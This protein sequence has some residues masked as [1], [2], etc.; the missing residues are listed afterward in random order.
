MYICIYATS[1]KTALEYGIGVGKKIE[2]GLKSGVV[3]KEF[4]ENSELHAVL[5]IK[6]K[7]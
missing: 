5:A 1:K 7:K 3:F 6:L 4:S 2:V